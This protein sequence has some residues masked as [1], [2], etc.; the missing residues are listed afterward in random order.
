MTE[1]KRFRI[2]NPSSDGT[3]TPVTLLEIWVKVEEGCD[4]VQVKSKFVSTAVQ[5]VGAKKLNVDNSMRKMFF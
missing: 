1:K 4:R 3:K 2:G 5:E